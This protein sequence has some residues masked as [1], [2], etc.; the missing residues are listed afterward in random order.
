M[1]LPL[2][3]IA[4]V[5]LLAACSS[6]NDIFVT[7]PPHVPSPGSSALTQ[8]APGN[9]AIALFDE[10]R[11]GGHS[12][13]WIGERAGLTASR[14][15]NAVYSVPPPGIAVHD[16][17]VSDFRAAGWQ[18]Q[19]DAA[20][21][22]DGSVGLTV[23]ITGSLGSTWSTAAS[24]ALKV[25]LM[26]A[27]GERTGTYQASCKDSQ[28]SWPEPEDIAKTVNRCLDGVVGQFTS[29]TLMARALGGS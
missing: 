29:D 17:L 12:S 27:T 18:V 4:L 6:G 16:A 8:T 23:T 25:H 22:I 13:G 28:L 5:G 21:K 15:S 7:L 9:I 2:A 24:A 10:Q 14:P 26:T 11:S 1:R 3:P 19:K 20:D